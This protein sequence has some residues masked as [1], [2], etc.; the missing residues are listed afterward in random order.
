M[1]LSIMMMMSKVKLT[2]NPVFTFK[3]CFLLTKQSHSI[4]WGF[5]RDLHKGVQFIIKIYD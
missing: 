4:L 5:L 2:V 3:H 1:S